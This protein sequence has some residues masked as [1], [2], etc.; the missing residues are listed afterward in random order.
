[1]Q[2]DVLFGLRDV[3][4]SAELGA[5]RPRPHV[6]LGRGSFQDIAQMSP[7]AGGGSATS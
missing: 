1:M 6:S 5:R 2:H 4:P 7:T 3:G